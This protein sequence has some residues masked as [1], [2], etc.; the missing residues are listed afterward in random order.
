MTKILQTLAIGSLVFLTGFFV[1][2]YWASIPQVHFSVKTH[3]CVRVVGDHTGGCDNLPT[4]YEA[5]W[6]E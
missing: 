6:V 1:L 5:I 3:A 4:K 2:A